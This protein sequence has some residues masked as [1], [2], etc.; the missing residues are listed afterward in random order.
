MA[1]RVLV[2]EDEARIQELLIMLLSDE[3][4]EVAAV[5]N[6]LMALE[7]LSTFQPDIIVLDLLM[8]VMDGPTF[9]QAY[10]QSPHR[11]VPVIAIS[12]S[13]HFEAD[14]KALGVAAF[15][16]KPFDL[17]ELVEHITHYI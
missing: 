3:N 12:A 1:K 2:V 9:L 17:N 13:K 7:Q 4:Y 16:L 11:Q 5:A 10:R 6:G 14:L 15:L 8:P